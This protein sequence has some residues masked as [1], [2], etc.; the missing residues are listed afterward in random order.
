MLHREHGVDLPPNGGGGGGA[1]G[2]AAPPLPLTQLALESRAAESPMIAARPPVG[3]PFASD[4][5]ASAASSKTPPAGG[6]GR[7]QRLTLS[8]GSNSRG[9][10]SRGASRTNTGGGP[11]SRQRSGSRGRA[12]MRAGSAEPRTGSA[13]PI[14]PTPATPLLLSAHYVPLPT[15]QGAKLRRQV[16]RSYKPATARFF[17]AVHTSTSG[18]YKLRE[19]ERPSS[20]RAAFSVACARDGVLPEP[21]L[22]R[23]MALASA[24]GKSAAKLAEDKAAAA[25]GAHGA[26]P[27]EFGAEP[28]PLSMA[29]TTDTAQAGAG[30]FAGGGELLG[31]LENFFAGRGGGGGG[32]G[33]GNPTQVSAAAG[34]L[35]GRPGG[36]MDATLMA[37]AVSGKRGVTLDLGAY[38]LGDTYSKPISEVVGKL[39]LCK[40]V[41]RDNRLTDGAAARIVDALRG[42]V[43]A[44]SRPPTSSLAAERDREYGTD[45][46]SMA[47][48]TH[49]DL[50]ANKLGH[51]TAASLS[52]LLVHGRVIE[53]LHLEFCGIKDGFT[54]RLALALS[55]REAA[56]P[57]VK[58]GAA[59]KPVPM[60]QPRR[61]RYGG[62][63]GDEPMDDPDKRQ[64]QQQRESGPR[65]PLALMVLPNGA[66]LGGCRRR[67]RV[68]P[69]PASPRLA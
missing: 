17:D 11:A 36:K 8:R 37:A 48:L 29:V 44:A 39:G 38:G 67:R 66:L 50:S 3:W 33:G 15:D 64:R 22:A 56:R 4:D 24:V 30:G 26:V 40:V 16:K 13:G 12:R 28:T 68:S 46:S 6:R 23:V 59:A 69:T 19:G 31:S 14:P 45:A 43:T 65:P 61:R 63:L 41:L 51:R 1:P 32:G 47:T 55:A 58:A 10:G 2:V 52:T 54:A 53:H 20:P 18:L 49:L 42:V 5:R 21:V 34:R 9:G 7:Q 57:V 35:G 60:L 27:G 25:R 62:H